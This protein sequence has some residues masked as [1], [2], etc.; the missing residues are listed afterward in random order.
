MMGIRSESLKDVR[1]TGVVIVYLATHK[2]NLYV[3][4]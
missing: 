4:N 1:I 2:I 3:P